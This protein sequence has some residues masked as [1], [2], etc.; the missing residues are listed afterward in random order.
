M[1]RTAAHGARVCGALA[2]AFVFGA[3]MAHATGAFSATDWTLQN[4]DLNDGGQ[5]TGAFTVSSTTGAITDWNLTTTKGSWGPGGFNYNS[6][7]SV[8][9]ED[10]S[11]LGG[12]VF[13]LQQRSLPGEPLL[14]AANARTLLL[15]FI[16]PFPTSPEDIALD[17]E[18]FVSSV[19]QAS[20][21]CIGAN[22]GEDVQNDVSEDPPPAV[23]INRRTCDAFGCPTGL[24]LEDDTA[25]DRHVP[26]VPEP[27][28]W[29]LMILGFGGVGAALRRSRIAVLTS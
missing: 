10:G 8:V 11:D 29:A 7:D 1:P 5:I 19:F 26:G 9:L 14:L 17:T 6:A 4:V 20:F 18:N 16:S 15:Y 2:A 13:E 28:A 12:L 22:C 3:P 25:R 23:G 21:E 27:A 24:A